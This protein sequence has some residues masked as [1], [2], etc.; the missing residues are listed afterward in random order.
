MVNSFP[1]SKIDRISL[2]ED[3]RS[4]VVKKCDDK[5]VPGLQEELSVDNM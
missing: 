2:W 3:V 1:V 5:M 4:N